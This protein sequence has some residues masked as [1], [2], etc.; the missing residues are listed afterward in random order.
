[1]YESPG[2]Y[3]LKELSDIQKIAQLIMPRIDFN[4]PET[5]D[6]AEMLVK[7]Y[8]VCGF[9]IF[10]GENEK[11]RQTASFLQSISEFPL[12]FGI[13]AERG[14]GQMLEGATYFP[15]LMSQGAI[16]D[17]EILK[18]QAQIT[19]Q[20]M[21][22]AGLNLIFAPVLDVNSNPQNPIV[23]IRSFG[24]DP[25]LVSE[26]G[27]V[28]IN[29]IQKH[30]ILSCCKHFPGHGSTS[31]DS[32]SDLPIIEKTYKELSDIDLVP[33]AFAIEN[34]VS[35]VMPAHISFP[36]IDES[37][38]P[39]TM[40][41][42]ILKD[43]LRGKL[44][45]N[46]LIISDSFKMD[47][48]NEFGDEVEN[49][50]EAVNAG[51]NI[52]LD[53]EEPITLIENLSSGLNNFEESVNGSLN[54]LFFHKKF[55]N[56]DFTSVKKPDFEQNKKVFETITRKSVCRL[57][58]GPLKN[59]KA[60]IYL[61]DSGKDKSFEFLTTCLEDQNINIVGKST[62][63]EKADISQDTSIIFVISTTV[64]AWTDKFN[65]SSE[66]C[67]FINSFEDLENEKI[68][69]NFGSPYVASNFNFLDT[70]IL[71]FDSIES[72]QASVIDALLGN[73]EPEGILPVNL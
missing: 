50:I 7:D 21:L 32:H 25:Q 4:V 1:M 38:K 62:D 5:V 9:I 71:S 12:L 68:L 30:G 37:R 55:I 18:K 3:S 47:A 13:D 40:S 17:I 29:E 15:F 69:L 20:E 67:N 14:L 59:D 44:G 49:T 45:F 8:S 19:A 34:K 46:G 72:C 22:F 58:G 43:I 31:V 36:K 66:T 54:K 35:S 42:T 41:E 63:F 51:V 61:F 52:I 60:L 70:V 65:L 39:A 28:F 33:F 27:T 24:D 64:S 2:V 10:N 57:K 16:N 6:R 73:V 53:P 26:L 11:V 23:N 56:A 48:L